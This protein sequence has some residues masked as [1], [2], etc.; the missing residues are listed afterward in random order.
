[1]LGLTFEAVGAVSPC[2]R[3]YKFKPIIRITLKETNQGFPP[4]P[5]NIRFMKRVL[6]ILSVLAV[7][8][9]LFAF[10]SAPAGNS[11]GSYWVN[12]GSQTVDFSHDR[13]LIRVG[14]HAGGFSKLK[15]LVTGADV[16][17]HGMT[18]TYAN[19]S[20]QTIAFKHRF[21]SNTTSRI[22]DL[23]GPKRVIKTVGFRY[24]TVKNQH[25]NATLR[26]MGKR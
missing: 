1:M 13:D 7:T 11:G 2:F 4:C 12:L 25:R 21:T 18:V 15:V 24:N 16:N 9:V 17:M 23:P 6:P 5:Q 14:R 20:K 19:G 8:V 22:I 10:T 3:L 26:V